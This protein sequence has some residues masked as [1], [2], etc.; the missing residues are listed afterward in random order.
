MFIEDLHG[1]I[2]D[3]KSEL[4]GVGLTKK[5]YFDKKKRNYE[6]EKST[7]AKIRCRWKEITR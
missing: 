3:A 6:T 1:G 2:N 7:W 5:K 4:Y